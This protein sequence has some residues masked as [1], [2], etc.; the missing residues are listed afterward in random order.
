MTNEKK[1]IILQTRCKVFTNLRINHDKHG[2]KPKKSCS[3]PCAKY[4]KDCHSTIMKKQ[5][6][7]TAALSLLAATGVQAQGGYQFERFF[8]TPY[9]D[10][11]GQT[12]PGVFGVFNKVSGNGKYAV[13]YDDQMASGAVYMWSLEK[14]DELQFIGNDYT[15]PGAACDVTNEGLVVGA[16]KGSVENTNIET[17]ELETVT[18]PVPAYRT[19][20]GEWHYLP[21]PADYSGAKASGMNLSMARAVTSDGKTI[22]GHFYVRTGIVERPWLME[23]VAM[24][25]VLWEL[26]D[27][28]YVL[29]DDFREAGKNSMLYK[30]GELKE[31]GE[32]EYNVFYVYG[33]SEDGKTIVG[34]NTSATGGFN[35]AFIRDGRLVQ[36]FDCADP[37]TPS[38]DGGIC[39]NIDA[40]GNIYGYFNH[41]VGSEGSASYYFVYTAD[42]K[43]EFTDTWYI[44]GTKD[45]KT[46]FPQY[47]NGLTNVMDCSDDGKVVVGGTMESAM[48]GAVNGPGVTY[49]DD[50]VSGVDRVEAIRD[51]VGI[52]YHGGLLVV[53]G[54][55]DRADVYNAQG[56]LVATGGQGK[57][58]SMEG[59]PAGAYIVKVTTADGVKSYK[60]AR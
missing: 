44:C 52:S 20:D 14:P 51:N 23:K 15:C 32:A 1:S 19:Q 56:A 50:V 41:E 31:V 42:G 22:V 4:N 58:F 40:A 2:L 39:N 7:F 17:G 8:D 12:S 53:T 27:G 5:L 36:L 16:F 11:D 57:A 34:M 25:P 48:G 59:N 37:D 54:E 13:G 29:K 21:I 47:Y 38:F 3:N 45:G 55:Y 28:E 46:R 24:F 18:C 49:D 30:D 43:L 60:F 10:I 35:P 9:T 33:L 26:E 6:L